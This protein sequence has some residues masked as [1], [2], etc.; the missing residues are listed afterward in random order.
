MDAVGNVGAGYFM[1][2]FEVELSDGRRLYAYK[3]QI[4]R[5]HMHLGP[6]GSAFVY[7]APDGYRPFDLDELAERVFAGRGYPRYP[8]YA[9]LERS[10]EW[11]A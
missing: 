8:A 2:M 3:H 5:Q 10:D 6:D 7:E 11:D 9:D 1:L 4:T